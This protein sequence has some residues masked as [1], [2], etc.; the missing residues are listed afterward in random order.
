MPA[1]SLTERHV[2]VTIKFDANKL[3]PHDLLDKV[4][5]R[6]WSLDGVSSV[7]AEVGEA[8]TRIQ[9]EVNY[10]AFDEL[11]RNLGIVDNVYNAI[12]AEPFNFSPNRQLEN[13]RY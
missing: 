3:S 4:A 12:D 13:V 6:L 8:Q 5:G 11:Q 1:K 7:Q 2:L 10:A 9:C